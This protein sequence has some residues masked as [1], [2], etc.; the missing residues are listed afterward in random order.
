MQCARDVFVYAILMT[1]VSHDGSKTKLIGLGVVICVTDR[2]QAEKISVP[3]SLTDSVC[4]RVLVK[5]KS[6]R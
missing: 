5:C 4:D 3:L 6:S 2:C 1:Q